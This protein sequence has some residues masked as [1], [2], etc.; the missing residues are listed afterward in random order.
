[1]INSANADPLRLWARYCEQSPSATTVVANVTDNVGVTGVVVSWPEFGDNPAGSVQLSP[2][3][4]SWS[5]MVG[6]FYPGSLDWTMT[7][8]DA[9]GNVSKPRTGTVTVTDCS[10]SVPG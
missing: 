3:G 4:N 8:T 10:T 6:G 9:A 7:A 1:V 2:N 5:G